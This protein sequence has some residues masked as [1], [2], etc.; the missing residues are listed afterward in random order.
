M[1]SRCNVWPSTMSAITWLRC[2]NFSNRIHPR[3]YLSYPVR[4]PND[5][6]DRVL[7]DRV[8]RASSI[9]LSLLRRSVKRVGG[10]K[11]K[12][13]RVSLSNPPFPLIFLAVQSLRKTSRMEE[14]LAVTLALTENSNVA[15]TLGVHLRRKRTAVTSSRMGG[16]RE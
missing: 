7:R 10:C 9:L 11:S 4:L 13:W 12:S 2:R 5:Q 15:Q 1:A 8:L 6:C 16:A 3:F 14:T